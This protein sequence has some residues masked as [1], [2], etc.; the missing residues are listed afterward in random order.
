[1]V[2]QRRSIA[3]C[4]QLRSC[5]DSVNEPIVHCLLCTHEEITVGVLHQP[6]K[7]SILLG[8]ECNNSSCIMQAIQYV[9]LTS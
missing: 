2:S 9:L 7:H 8:K 6:A 4:N 5:D 1:M 3:G